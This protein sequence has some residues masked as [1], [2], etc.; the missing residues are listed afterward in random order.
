ML[1]VYNL[2]YA[3]VSVAGSLVGGLLL[4]LGGESY[5]A[6]LVVFAISAACRVLTLPLFYLPPRSKKMSRRSSGP[7]K[8]TTSI[9]AWPP[10]CKAPAIRPPFNRRLRRERKYFGIH[11]DP[12]RKAVRSVLLFAPPLAKLDYMKVGK[13]LKLLHQ[14]GWYEVPSKG[15]HP[16]F[17]H[18]VKSGR[19][20]VSGKRSHELPPKTL[21]S[22]LKQAGLK[23]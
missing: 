15:G 1:T 12:P 7:P 18:P 20:T 11:R 14:D 16:Q 21:N 22:I 10:R 5:T 3:I 9:A 23:E 19:V 17:K 8:S 6:Y 13:V 4:T 2:G